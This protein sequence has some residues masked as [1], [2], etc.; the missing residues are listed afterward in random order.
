MLTGVSQETDIINSE[1][2]PD[3]VYPDM[4]ALLA[5]YKDARA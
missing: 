1:I 4:P 5:D 3:W 2:K